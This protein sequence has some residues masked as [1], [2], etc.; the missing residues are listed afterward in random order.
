M[1]GYLEFSEIIKYINK[2][3]PDYVDSES[4][5]DYPFNKIIYSK[6]NQISDQ[7]LSNNNKNK[8]ARD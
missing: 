3:F 1:K 8:L 2:D 7:M 6:N 4:V 5:N